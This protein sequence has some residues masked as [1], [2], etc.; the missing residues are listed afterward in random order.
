MFPIIL[1]LNLFILPI[2][3]YVHDSMLKV[4]D[5]S[6][7]NIFY[8]PNY[9]GD[10]PDDEF[11]LHQY[12]YQRSDCYGYLLSKDHILTATS[13]FMDLTRISEMLENQEKHET[14]LKRIFDG[15]DMRPNIEKF[16][17]AQLFTISLQDSS[18]E[19]QI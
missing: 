12:Q 15:K 19:E 11:E 2:K 6:E 10:R 1:L 17:V 18:D 9:Y 16:E 5:D 8:S 4:W 3:G 7:V 14:I 13:C